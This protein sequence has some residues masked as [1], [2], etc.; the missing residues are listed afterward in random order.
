VRVTRRR[1]LP[2]LAAAAALVLGA[3]ALIS[4]WEGERG[5]PVLERALAAIGD[6]PVLHVVMHEH[7]SRGQRFDVA[8]GRPLP[9]DIERESWIDAERGRI[10]MVERQDGEVITDAIVRMGGFGPAQTAATL[11]TEYRRGLERDEL[12]VARTGTIAGRRVH[13]LRSKIV[14]PQRPVTEIAVDAETYE[15]VRMATVTGPIRTTLDFESFDSRPRTEADFAVRF[16]PPSVVRETRPDG[17]RVSPAAAARAVSGA[18]WTGERISTLPR[19]ELRAGGWEATLRDGSELHGVILTV[20][21]GERLGTAIAPAS[22]NP[23][24]VEIVQAADD[25]PAR[26]FLVPGVHAPPPPPEG[27][28]D[29]GAESSPSGEFWVA[30]LRKPGVWIRVRA[31][32]RELLFATVRSLRPIS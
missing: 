24:G 19:R 4:P 21:Y 22:G 16:A 7:V 14:G 12:R 11:A 9:F 27:T 5:N 18:T 32:S 10:H 30:T 17:E 6:G 26:R 8:T 31:S 15:P 20:A 1:L 29:L 13:W 3:L 25:S 2:A 23:T 28:F